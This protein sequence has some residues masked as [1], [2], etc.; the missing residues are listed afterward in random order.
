MPSSDY[1]I[2]AVGTSTAP[3]SRHL[4]A[5]VVPAGQVKPVDAASARV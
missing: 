1:R 3:L 4:P 5:M 2:N